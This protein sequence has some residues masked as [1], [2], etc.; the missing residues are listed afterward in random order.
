MSIKY[1]KIYTDGGARGNPGPAGVG[2]VF[3]DGKGK[4]IKEIS[5]YIGRGTNNQAEYQA[6]I[7]ALEEVKKIKA[8]RIEF[9]SDSEL[10]VNQ[11]NRKYK[12][13]NKELGLLF[14]KVWNLI[15]SF[16]KVRF[17]Y[18]PRNKNKKADNL[19]QR[20]ILHR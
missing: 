8:S 13:K 4:I 7:L 5:K 16:E 12:I 1:L 15:Q 3:C 18:I 20:A 9:F 2:I 14:V 11:L 6:I 19:V 17:Y 10:I